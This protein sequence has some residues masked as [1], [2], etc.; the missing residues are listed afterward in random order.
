MKV[1]DYII[2]FL[3]K[4]GIKDMFYLSGGGCMHLLNSLAE[5]E[6]INGVAMQHEQAV[7]IAMESYA[8]VGECPSVALVTTGPG[9][10][11]AITGALS[12]YIDSM[13]CLILSGQVK[14]SDL[15]SQYDVRALGSQEADIVTMVKEITKYAVTVINPQDIK[16]CLEKAW[17]LMNEGRK[18][19]VWIDVP[20][21]VQSADIEEDVVKGYEIPNLIETDLTN[22]LD[23]L[24]KMIEEAKRPI[25]MLGNGVRSSRGLDALIDK[26]QIPVIPSW[27]GIDMVSNTSP[28]Y[29]GKCGILGDRVGNF[30]VQTA[31]FILS[32]GC[33]LD[34]SITGYNRSEWAPHAKKVVVEIDRA[35]LSKLQDANIS[36]EINENAQRVIDDL[37]ERKIHHCDWEKWYAL[38]EKWKAQYTVSDTRNDGEVISTYEL[39]DCI[40]KLSS[41]ES[42]IVPCSA[43]TVAEIFHQAFSVKKGQIIR[44]NHGLGA[45]GYELPAAIGAYYALRKPVICVAGDGGIQLNIQELATIAGNKLPIRIIVVNNGGYSSIRGMQRAHFNGHYFGSNEESGLYLPDMCKIAS[46][47]GLETLQINHKSELEEKIEYVLKSKGPILCN[48]NV[49]SSCVVALKCASRVLEDGKIISSSLEDMSPLLAET[50]IREQIDSALNI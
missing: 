23:E 49:D 3:E 50:E 30:A 1:S 41:K 18:G 34:Y 16:Y 21:D 37:L 8:F 11:N 42:I 28:L 25:L 26:L 4:R 40:A 19:V 2:R 14:T 29:V 36:L 31:D 32:L 9:A 46:A 47:Y 33:R 13:P 45:M 43:G 15:R 39:V 12:A 38:I 22:T 48:V 24:A 27:K 5:S 7:S 17:Y 20:L 35:E 10:T 44:S 6:R